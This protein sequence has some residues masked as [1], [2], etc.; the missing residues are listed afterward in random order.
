MSLVTL[1]SQPM[2]MLIVQLGIGLMIWHWALLPFTFSLPSS[3]ILWK[4]LQ[5]CF[6][7]IC[8]ITMARLLC[9]LSTKISRRL[10]P[11]ISIPISILLPSLTNWLLLLLNLALL[12]LA[13][14]LT[15]ATLQFSLRCK[16]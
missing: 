12:A 16:P 1:P 7:T 4:Q 5:R 9:H 10:S 8:G 15:F 11:S 3:R 6:G 2:A 14:E 13:L